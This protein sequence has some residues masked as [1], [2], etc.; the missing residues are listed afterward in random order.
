MS[1]GTFKI[2]VLPVG[3]NYLEEV[4]DVQI[5][6]YNVG[7]MITSDS[8]YLD[9]Y[10]KPD[11][12]QVNTSE[13]NAPGVVFVQN[14]PSEAQ[15]IYKKAVSQ[16]ENS[17]S[18]DLGLENLKRAVEIFP[19]YFD[20]LNRLGIEYMRREKYFEALP[21]LIKAIQIN[22]RSS[23]S[24]YALGIAAYNL[25]QI[26]EASEA[27]RATTILNPQSPDAF[28]QYG[29]MLRISNNL[30]QAENVLLKA[31]EL[32]RD[33]PRSDIHWQLGLLYDKTQRYNQAADELEVYLKIEKDA[34]NVQQIRELIKL[35]RT[36]A[37]K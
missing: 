36:K 17:K 2:K 18:A 5:V 27:F 13:P 16:L 28:L 37:Q 26:K 4:R 29:K 34:P 22:Q 21:Y 33:F 32:A 9:I 3:T 31:K 6:N 24:F 10:L 12:R 1:S 20:A 14:I 25:K 7:N 19:D 35:F 30:T 11:K 23:S 8:V 15:N